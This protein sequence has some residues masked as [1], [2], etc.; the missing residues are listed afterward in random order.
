M[1]LFDVDLKDKSEEKNNKY[2]SKLSD[3]VHLIQWDRFALSRVSG[4]A[5]GWYSG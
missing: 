4:R 5:R 1:V 3:S 2:G